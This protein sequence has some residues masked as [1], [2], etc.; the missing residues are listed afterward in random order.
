[1]EHAQVTKHQLLFAYSYLES[2]Q[3][4]VSQGQIRQ[5][6]LDEFTRMGATHNYKMVKQEGMTM[7]EIF[8]PKASDIDMLQNSADCRCYGRSLALSFIHKGRALWRS[9]ELRNQCQ[10][11]KLV[12]DI[13]LMQTTVKDGEKLMIYSARENSGDTAKYGSENVKF[14]KFV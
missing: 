14:Y 8:L 9:A 10:D 6:V 3:T 11:E 7:P 13:M 4:L 5:R 1:M 2:K 12:D